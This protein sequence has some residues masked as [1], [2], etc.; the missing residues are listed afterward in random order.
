MNWL[1]R[2]LHR[3]RLVPGTQWWHDDKHLGLCQCGV[4]L[5]ENRPWERWDDR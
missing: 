4:V 1:R 3:H 2:L 5:L